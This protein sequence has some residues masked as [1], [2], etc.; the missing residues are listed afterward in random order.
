VSTIDIETLELDEGALLL[1]RRALA[2]LPVGGSLHV[3]GRAP[4][5][6]M[7][8]EAWCR[9][10]GHG[11]QTSQLPGGEAEA[12]VTRGPL[13]DG[14]WRDAM[15]TGHSQLAEHELPA[16][17]ADPAWGLAARGATVEAGSPDFGFHLRNRDELWAASAGE[18]YLLA[19]AGQWDPQTAI[20][21]DA[22]FDLAPAIE[23]AVAQV[24]TYLIENENAALVV[25][26]RHLGQV[27]PHFREVQQVLALQCADEARHIEVFTRRLGLR[28]HV[29]MLS[30]A[31]GQASL[32]TL[33]QTPDFSTATFL[34]SV[35]GEGSFVNLLHF[36]RENAPDPVTRQIC[37]LAARDEARH[38]AF[39][40]A[41]LEHR[42]SM[43]PD[44]LP[45]LQNAIEQRHEQLAGTAGLNEEVFDALVLLAAGDLTPTAVAR[46]NAAVQQL[47]FDMAAG[48]KAR[49]LRLGFEPGQAQRLADM[50]TR[51]F[52]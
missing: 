8:L 14:R 30:T 47:K 25:P 24:M 46:G 33:L 35:L 17:Q 19:A 6:E 5:W 2:E 4:H 41:H 44:Y 42:L 11:M 3:R 32:Q 45:R 50:H 1:V 29:P 31:G 18:L 37:R 27:H 48:R 39:G 23:A 12:V 49:L 34:L 52:M 21:W 9:Q 16:A 28:G 43:Q 10:Q 15:I 22:P 40:M 26:A 38:V 36:L 20:D 7:H 13:S 51:N